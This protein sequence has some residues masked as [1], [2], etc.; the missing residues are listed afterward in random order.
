MNQTSRLSLIAI[1]FLS[2]SVDSFS[3]DWPHQRGPQQNGIMSPGSIDSLHLKDEPEILWKEAVADGY[4]APIIVKDIVIY[5]DLQRGK[6]TYT[7]IKLGDAKPLWKDVL[8]SPHKDGFGTGPRCAPVSDGEIVL[9]QSCKGELHCLDL[10]SGDLQWSKNYTKDFGSLYIGEKGNALGASRHGYTASPFIDGD[11]VIALAGGKGA[12]IVCLNKNNGKVIW[13]SQDDQAAFSPPIV[14]T[15]AGIKQ[16]V[17][18]TVK[19]LVGVDRADGKLLWRV[20]LSTSYG[21]HVVAPTIYNDMVIVGSHEVGLIAVKVTAKG[22]ELIAEESWKLGKEMAPNFASPICMGDNL[23]L[24]AKKQVLCIDAKTGKLAWSKDG[25]VKTSA[26]QAFAAFV[27]LKDQVMMLNDMGE[28]ILFEADPGSYKET[29][30]VQVCGKNW[31]HPAYSN[32]KL[33]IRDS[34]KLI[35]LD[36]KS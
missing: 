34:R 16:V 1:F 28:L 3:A 21:R 13:K 7:A 4:A 33:L 12:G 26:G 27:G 6:E 8:D 2:V 31:C 22:K 17:C 30:R 32:G 23:Y 29:G 19:G 9:L 5:G 10:L 25:N 14:T 36:L 11:H 35:C 15:L 20:P 18:F 24:L